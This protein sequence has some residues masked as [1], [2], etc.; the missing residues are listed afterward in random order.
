MRRQIVRAEVGERDLA[1]I[2]IGS[3][4]EVW[5]D[6]S[7]R[8]WKGHVTELAAVMGRRSARSLDPTDRFDRD[9]REAIIMLDDPGVPAV[10]GLRV[11]VGFRR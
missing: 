7:P 6:G 1:G 3:P 8:R 11:T 9:V 4:V 2:A 10:A 5:I